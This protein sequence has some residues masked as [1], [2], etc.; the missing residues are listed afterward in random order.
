VDNRYVPIARLRPAI[1][2]LV[3]LAALL[4][5]VLARPPAADAYAVKDA[6][7][8]K[9]L[10][11]KGSGEQQLFAGGLVYG[12]VLRGGRVVIEFA[13]KVTVANG[14]AR[15]K[16]KRKQIWVANSRKPMAFKVSGKAFRVTVV[17]NSVLNGV[18]IWGFARFSGVGTYTLDGSEE[19]AWGGPDLDLGA[20][21]DGTVLSALESRAGGLR[22]RLRTG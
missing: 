12:T 10:V 15:Q 9:A 4:A 21:P 16:S 7:A 3:A 22:A 8:I 1:T 14:Q 11:S 5:V 2:L 13:D 20:A 17:G 19:L 18:G 6:F